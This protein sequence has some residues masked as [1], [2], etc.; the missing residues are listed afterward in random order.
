MKDSDDQARTDLEDRVEEDVREWRDLPQTWML[1][2]DAPAPIS[3][4]DSD[5]LD[6]R[7][8]EMSATALLRS[9]VPPSRLVGWIRSTAVLNELGE[10]WID[11]DRE[12][13]ECL[14]V[15]GAPRLN[16][17]VSFCP[18]C[19]ESRDEYR[20]R[21]KPHKV[22]VRGLRGFFYLVSSEVEKADPADVLPCPYVA[23]CEV[24]GRIA[25]LV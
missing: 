5:G 8:F 13:L 18:S 25:S 6:G 16:G 22:R 23:A 10:G 21:R 14:A 9:G 11:V 1:V 12:L 2:D 17:P 15:V 20:D 24:L 4:R 19:G 3:G 7:I